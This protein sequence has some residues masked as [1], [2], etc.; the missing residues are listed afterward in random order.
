VDVVAVGAL[1]SLNFSFQLQITF[2]KTSEC[3]YMH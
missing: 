2:I 1:C 3:K